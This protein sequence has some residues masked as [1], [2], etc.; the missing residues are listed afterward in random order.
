M[1]WS[2]PAPP[3]CSGT[4]RPSRPSFASPLSGP[5]EFAGFVNAPRLGALPSPQIRVR[6][7][8]AAGVPRTGRNPYA[9]SPSL[10]AETSYR[11][12]PANQFRLGPRGPRPLVASQRVGSERQPQHIT[13]LERQCDLRGR[14][15]GAASRPGSTPASRRLSP[16]HD[17]LFGALR[18]V[19]DAGREAQPQV[20]HARRDGHVEL[21][22]GLALDGRVLPER[23]PGYA[24]DR[25]GRDLISMPAPSLL[26][27][28]SASG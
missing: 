12:Q 2:A 8:A 19:A 20:A 10:N 21:D 4:F 5:G 9:P 23:G 3:N 22:D 18:T 24:V 26:A 7:S 17:K 1:T 15:P 14:P 16:G 11:F 27:R 13:C 6:F 28:V 25:R